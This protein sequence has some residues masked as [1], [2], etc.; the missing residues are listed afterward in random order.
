MRED[1]GSSGF[2]D[3]GAED[4][5]AATDAPLAGRTDAGA[6]ATGNSSG[7]VAIPQTRRIRS[8]CAGVCDR[9]TTELAVEP[10]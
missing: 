2:A 1:R 7:T 9:C 8:R 10:G 6:T 4:R 3:A 5:T